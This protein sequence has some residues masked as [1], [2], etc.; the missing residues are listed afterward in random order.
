MTWYQDHGESYSYGD[1]HHQEEIHQ[2]WPKQ[3]NV[4]VIDY[5]LTQLTTKLVLIFSHIKLHITIYFFHQIV[6][7]SQIL[8]TYLIATVNEAHKFTHAVAMIIWRPES[9]LS[10]QPSGWKN[11][12]IK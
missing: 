4:L 7:K 2:P 6:I 1:L 8:M 5:I 9:V 3:T 12:K 10:N 11:D